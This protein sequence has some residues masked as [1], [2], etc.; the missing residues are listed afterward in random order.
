M[1]SQAKCNN[2]SNTDYF[3]VFK[4]D[5]AQANQI[6][7]CKNCGLMYSYPLNIDFDG[8]YWEASAKE[9]VFISSFPEMTDQQERVKARDY[10]SSINY[11][12]KIIP[13]KGRALE[14]GASKGN[15][16]NL[17]EKR[18]WQVT[19]I[20][21]SPERADKAKK[22]FGYDLILNKL[23]DTNL[24]DNSFDAIFM[25]HAIEHVL[26][27]SNVISILYRYLKPGGLLVI[28][29]PTYDSIPFYIL[30][31]RERSI[32]CDSHYFFFTKKLLRQMMEKH[33]FVILRHERVGRTLTLERLFWNISVMIRGKKVD[34]LLAKISSFLKFKSIKIY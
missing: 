28:E 17:L 14:V 4:E 27:P 23:E 21:P 10:I 31:H 16:L 3:V 26:D 6:V 32:R 18:G 11:V 25:F 19:G 20:E 30:R 13:T 34:R 15:F 33:G 29:T 5:L 7:K 22:T 1:S 2:C 9:P 24:S 8:S 12:E